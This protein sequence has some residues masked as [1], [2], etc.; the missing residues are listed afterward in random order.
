V[1]ITPADS[2]T[3][4]L[5]PGVDQFTF[6]TNVVIRFLC[7]EGRDRVH[8]IVAALTLSALCQP[9]IIDSS[10]GTGSIGISL[11]AVKVGGIAPPEI[12]QILECILAAVLRWALAQVRIP[13][14]VFTIGGVSLTLQEGPLAEDDQIDVRGDIS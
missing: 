11:L 6:S 5:P 14:Q 4:P 7:G 2:A 10:P 12:E 13:F 1:D 8:E 9:D 3:E